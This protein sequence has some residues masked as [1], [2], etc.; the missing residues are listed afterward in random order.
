MLKQVPLQQPGPKGSPFSSSGLQQ[1]SLK[2]QIPNTTIYANICHQLLICNLKACL[3]ASDCPT[4]VLSG[5]VV[6]VFRDVVGP[7][8][9]QVHLTISQWVH[10]ELDMTERARAD[11]P[12]PKSRKPISSVKQV[13][14]LCPSQL[15]QG[16]PEGWRDIISSV[17]QMALPCP[18][19]LR[20][21]LPEGWRDIISSVKQMAL[22]CPSQL[23]QGLPE[24]WREGFWPLPEQAAWRP[25][26]QLPRARPQV[27]R[28]VVPK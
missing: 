23:R 15:R 4:C 11:Q 24:D 25:R 12:P 8:K 17:K 7:T 19:Q 10:K 22:L 16:L 3:T 20:Q 13:A 28:L 14:L 9:F 5:W 21:G 1:T 6:R 27:L 18:S 26:V 2:V